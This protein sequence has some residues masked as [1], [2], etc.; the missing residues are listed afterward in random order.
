VVSWAER[1]HD[2]AEQLAVVEAEGR[3]GADEVQPA[4]LGLAHAQHGEVDVAARVRA[5]A[6]HDAHEAAREAAAR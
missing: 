4:V 3:A 5:Q 2:G 6:P 1:A